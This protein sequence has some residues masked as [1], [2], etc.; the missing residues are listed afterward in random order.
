MDGARA[1]MCMT[2]DGVGEAQETNNRG[3]YNRTPKGKDVT[4]TDEMDRCLTELL[5]KQVML[6][7][8][9]EKN[10]KTSA[11]VAVLI[12][13]NERFGLNLTIENVVSRLKTWK[14]QY[15]LLK[16][17]LYQGGFKW[18]EERKIVVATDS[19][20]NEYIKVYLVFLHINFSFRSNLGLY[21]FAIAV[22]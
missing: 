17:M 12:V 14:R 2:A 4:W 10:F 8:K 7:N 3:T 6:G 22:L 18:D 15:G 11:Y 5:V 19:K 13:L 16:E 9:L 20:W 21:L 1:I